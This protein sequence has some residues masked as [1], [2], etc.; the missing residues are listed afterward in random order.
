MFKQQEPLPQDYLDTAINRVVE[1]ISHDLDKHTL[2]DDDS[3][4]VNGAVE[5]SCGVFDRLRSR[6]WLHCWDIAAA[7]EMTDRPVFVKLGHGN[8][9]TR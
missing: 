2:S 4:I 8:S 7:L 5:L 6:E 9:T 3:M 1:R